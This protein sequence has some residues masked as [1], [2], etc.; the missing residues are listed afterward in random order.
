[1][2]CYLCNEVE[3]VERPGQVRDYSDLKVYEC[4][5]CGL[6]TLS[7]IDHIS[8]RHYE[9]GKMHM[10]DVSIIEWLQETEIDDQRRFEML[11]T[12]LTGKNI[13]DFG[14][15]NGVFLIKA[16]S[17]SKKC[18]G[19]ELEER[20]QSF[21]NEQK[22][23][24]WLS[25]KELTEKSNQRFD[26][27][28]SFHVFEHMSDPALFLKEL[29][30]LITEKGEIII[31]VPSSDDALITLYNNESFSNFTYWSQ[32]LFLFNQRTMAELVKKAGLRLNWVKQIQRYSLANHLHWLAK[33][34]PGGHKVWSFFDSKQ[35]DES[36]AQQLASIGKCDTIMASI[37]L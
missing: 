28:T 15:G 14:C 10:G 33:G 19:V 7:S 4:V 18:E 29:S 3:F 35:L 20:L 16:N 21:F 2:N 36:Y 30:K 34:K 26:L 12:K 22:I 37:S 31:E 11:K 24:V 25:L 23:K 17:F 32:H 8:V 13:L 27:I 5:N 6:V 1:M 9:E